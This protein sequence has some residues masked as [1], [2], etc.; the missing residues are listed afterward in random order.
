MRTLARFRARRAYRRRLAAITAA[1]GTTEH[2]LAT[3][4]ALDAL[5]LELEIAEVA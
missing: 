2:A 3:A 1:F 5:E 4:E